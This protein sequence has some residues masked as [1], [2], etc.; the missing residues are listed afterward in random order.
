MSLLASVEGVPCLCCML[1]KEV[2]PAACNPTSC[3][4]LD[5]W[6]QNDCSIPVTLLAPRP[7]KQVKNRTFLEIP[8][9]PLV[10]PHCGSKDFV[11][12][13]TSIRNGKRIPKYRCNRCRRY[14]RRAVT[15]FVTPPQIIAYSFELIDEKELSVRAIAK[16]IQK[17]FN[18]Y[19][20]GKTVHN[21]SKNP[22]LRK[23]VKKVL[24]KLKRK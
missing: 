12:N 19:V 6:L 16:A 13:G 22:T 10:C 7:A 2:S 23:E 15:R 11:R 1:Q 21:W 8:R 14:F 24:R 17:K 4:K 5:A 3:A 18:Y 20:T 9:V